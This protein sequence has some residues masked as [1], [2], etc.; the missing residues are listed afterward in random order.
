[1]LWTKSNALPLARRPVPISNPR[2]ISLRTC[3]LGP[4]RVSNIVLVKEFPTIILEMLGKQ[5]KGDGVAQRS[6]S[7]LCHW[8]IA[9]KPTLSVCTARGPTT[10]L[11][12]SQ[13]RWHCQWHGQKHN[14][15]SLLPLSILHNCLPFA[16]SYWSSSSRGG[17]VI[18]H[19]ASGIKGII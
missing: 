14:S 15:F 12:S 7:S 1:M 11:N 9:C 13:G 19:T 5:R 4:H 2:F 6:G 8:A 18:S 3:V 10:V 17:Y 16:E